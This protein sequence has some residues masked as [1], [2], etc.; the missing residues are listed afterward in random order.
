M[1]EWFL[2]VF[3]PGDPKAQGSLRHVGNGR[4]VHGKGMVAWRKH[5][6]SVFEQWAGT[7]FGGW[8]AL[9]EPV[10]VHA[11]FFLPRPKKPR[12]DNAATGLDLDKL[13]R[14]AGDALEQSGVL[15]ND[16]RIVRWRAEKHWTHDIEGQDG[17]QAGVRVKVRKIE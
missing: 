2:N 15:R 9:D 4:M 5:M 1:S 10:E 17:H 7:W 6:T 11:T 8:E 12:L 14:C 3:V 16:A 13:Q